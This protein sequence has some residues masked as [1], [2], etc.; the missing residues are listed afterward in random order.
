LKL[1]ENELYKLFRTKKLY[2]FAAVI[3][4][5]V[6]LNLSGYEPG[7]ETTIWTFTGGQSAPLAMIQILSQFM[8]I[9]IPIYIGD[10]LTNEY[11]QGTLKLSLLRPVARS[12]L[13]KA[14]TA[15]LFVFVCVMVIFFN[16]AAYA[17]GTY[18]LGWGNGTEYA[19]QLYRPAEGIG[20]TLAANALLIFP[21]MAYGLLVLA[22]A[23]FS[24]SMSLT[25]ISSLLAMTIGLNTNGF[26]AVAPYSLA[27]HVMNFHEHFIPALDLLPALRSTGIVGIYAA[28]FALLS[29][30]AFGK[31]EIVY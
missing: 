11:R 12:Q 23:V 20:L 6:L 10:S 14:K 28:A 21:Y 22:I 27:Y 17:V 8:V 13:L 31:K 26:E 5:V 16:A 1:M 15:S 3:L 7:S 29:F 30:K 19:G 9:F 18:Y 24:S 2:V 4:V 25:V